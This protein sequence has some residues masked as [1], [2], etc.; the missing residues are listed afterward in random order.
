MP[1][2]N[3]LL[4]SSRPS[5]EVD[6]RANDRLGEGLL[7]LQVAETL[8]GLYRCEA[9]FG[10]W[11]TNSGRPGFLYFD[12]Q[13]L[14]FGKAFKVKLDDAT[15]FDGRVMALEAEFPADRPPEIT[16]LA[17]DRLQDLRMTRRTRTFSNQSDADVFQQI[18]GDHGLSPDIDLSGPTHKVLAQVNQ[19]DLSFLRDR[20]RALGAELKVD[21]STFRVATRSTG[22]SNPI[23]L[24]HGRE[25]R[26][27]TVLADLAHQRTALSA[28]GWDVSAKSEIR[29]ETGDSALGGELEDGESGA[30]LLQ[31]ALGERKDSVAHG[32]PATGDEARC[33]AESAFRLGARRFLRGR[34][35]AEPAAG[36]S[37]GSTVDLIGLGPLFSGKYYV[38]E[39]RHRFDGKLG[40]R[41][42]FSCERPWIGRV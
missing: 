10:N 14:D 16:V 39:L 18:A 23:E 5:F 8:D 20:A 15:L 19:S 1:P 27:F 21:G 9:T 26:T 28:T 7:R 29:H 40:L 34:G 33:I 13:T 36:L 30:S 11:G 24:N 42:E 25:L 17:E 12:R 38:F 31:S 4:Q 35:V 2:A 22:G 32:V 41:T 6:G 3:S 37:V